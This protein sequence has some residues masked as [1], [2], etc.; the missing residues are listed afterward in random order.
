M[1]QEEWDQKMLPEC[2]RDFDYSFESKDDLPFKVLPLKSQ[3]ACAEETVN[4]D[5]AE[6]AEETATAEET[7]NA[8]ETVNDDEAD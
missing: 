3:Q 4:T 6:N 5:E 8:K 2:R 1:T 7:E